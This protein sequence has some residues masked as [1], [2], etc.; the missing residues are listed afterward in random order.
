MHIKGAFDTHVHFAP[1]AKVKANTDALSLV[2]LAAENDMAGLVLKCNCFPSVGIAYLA[3]LICPEL[4]VFGGIVINPQIGGLNPAAVKAAISYGE[5]KT[6]EYCRFVCLPTFYSARDIE[7]YH[8]KETPIGLV[9]DGKVLDDLKRILDLV[10]ENSL[11]LLTGHIGEREL[12]PVVEQAIR[13][14]VRNIVLSHPSSPVVNI[15]LEAQKAFGE[16]GA[17]MQQCCV[18]TYP[19][20]EK[21]YGILGPSF[22]DLAKA[23][24]FVGTENCIIATDMGADAGVNPNPIGGFANYINELEKRGFTEE[25]ISVMA[26]KHPLKLYTDGMSI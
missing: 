12:F 19:Y 17:V 21:K 6:A 26:A 18:E 25:E 23:I 15:S 11:V 22:D 2:R 8:K 9:K 4:K 1:H 3:H 14:G 7:F 24:R 5:G 13:Q 20:Y 16:M 10:A